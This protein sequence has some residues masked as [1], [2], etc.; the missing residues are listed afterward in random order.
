MI[1][2]AEM[3]VIK[4]RRI[5]LH[6]AVGWKDRDDEIP[7]ERNTLFNI[8]SMTKPVVGTAVQMLVDEEKLALDDRAAEYLPSFDNEKSGEITVEHLLTHRSGLPLTLLTKWPDYKG[9]QEIAKE[10]GEHGP[11]F[12]PGTDFGY[13]DSGSDSLGAV[14]EKASGISPLSKRWQRTAAPARTGAGFRLE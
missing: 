9:L 5:V 6:E 12:E 3:V 1:V 2:G 11:A 14:L 10:A 13:S 8:R 4:N 7:M